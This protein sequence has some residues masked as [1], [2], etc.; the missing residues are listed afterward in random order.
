M[1]NGSRSALIPPPPLR[2]GGEVMAG[3]RLDDSVPVYP[4]EALKKRV[5][6]TVLVEATI[7]EDGRVTDVRV[8]S[9]PPLLIQAALDCIAKFR[10]QPTLLNGV[11]TEVKTTI[12]IIFRL[13]PFQPPH[14]K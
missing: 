12:K 14:K 5:M 6:G 2:V 3:K 7:S 13:I 1:L 9:G 8:V 10:Y 4:A 11:P